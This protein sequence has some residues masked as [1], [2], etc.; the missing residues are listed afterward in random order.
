[1]NRRVYWIVTA[2]VGSAVL[3]SPLVLA[4]PPRSNVNPLK[5]ET[6]QEFARAHIPNYVEAEEAVKIVEDDPR[7]RTVFFRACRAM[8]KKSTNPAA[9]LTYLAKPYAAAFVKGYDDPSEVGIPYELDVNW[10]VALD[11][12]E[13]WMSSQ[14]FPT[15]L[16]WIHPDDVVRNALIDTHY[17]MNDR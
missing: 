10:F 16:P 5:Y 7:F 6:V 17:I 9:Y 13:A 4:G 11:Q 3:L 14:V 8:R 15:N 2:I 1:M 12:W